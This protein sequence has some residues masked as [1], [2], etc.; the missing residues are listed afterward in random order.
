VGGTN[1]GF[2][3]RLNDEAGT[4]IATASNPK[5][6]GSISGTFNPGGAA[7]LAAFDDED[8]SGVWQ[9]SITDDTTSDTGT[10]FGWTLYDVF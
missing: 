10:L 7:V 5:A 3:I 8:A 6:D 4:D 2:N 9:L 1:E